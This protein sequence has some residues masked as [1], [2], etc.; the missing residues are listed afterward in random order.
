M[1]VREIMKDN[2]VFCTEETPLAKVYEMM[3]ENCCDFVAVVESRAH[4]I[5]IGI[6]TEHDICKQIIGR[7]RNPRDMSAAN[8]MNSNI[9]K[10]S[11]ATDLDAC[12][13]AMKTK[14]TSRVFIIDENGKLCGTLTRA[15]IE[16]NRTETFTKTV[17][18]PVELFNYRSPGVNRIF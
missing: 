15:D 1:F 4:F 9:V 12:L 8:V 3:T 11:D 16:Q 18:A 2:S 10:L 14:Q 7:G 17:F 6:I 13:E 5:P